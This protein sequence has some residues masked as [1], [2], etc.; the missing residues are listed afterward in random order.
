MLRNSTNKGLPLAVSKI[1]VKILKILQVIAN[2]VIT[3]QRAVCHLPGSHYKI[4]DLK[5]FVQGK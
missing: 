3:G 5:L 1:L 4:A 2:G